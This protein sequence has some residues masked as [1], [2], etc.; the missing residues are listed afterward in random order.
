MFPWMH[1]L[2]QADIH[3]RSAQC[4]S[5]GSII[6]KTVQIGPRSCAASQLLTKPISPDFERTSTMFEQRL[7]NHCQLLPVMAVQVSI[8]CAVPAQSEFQRRPRR[9][10][11]QGTQAWHLTATN[12]SF[13]NDF[14][15]NQLA[16]L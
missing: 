3:P 5:R 9:S 1:E 14:A 4:R 11:Q 6:L 8:P 7:T 10:V 2:Q 12:G 13:Q 16:W 15:V